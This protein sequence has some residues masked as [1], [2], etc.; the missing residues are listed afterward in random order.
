[1]SSPPLDP[2][3]AALRANTPPDVFVVTPR[4]LR[5][6]VRNRI[7]STA[8]D[9]L[10]V[11]ADFCVALQRLQ[12]W[13]YH[14]GK[15]LPIAFHTFCAYG[16]LLERQRYQ[17]RHLAFPVREGLERHRDLRQ[18]QS[19]LDSGSLSVEDLKRQWHELFREEIPDRDF[20]EALASH[21]DF[22]RASKRSRTPSAVARESGPASAK[23][24]AV[25]KIIG[26][27]GEEGKLLPRKTILRRLQEA[28]IS[29]GNEQLQEVLDVLRGEGVY[30]VLPNKRRKSRA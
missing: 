23:I 26:D 14:D 8:A 16:D 15:F 20:R 5:G 4:V 30:T 1:M 10:D 7:I 11:A 27:A 17:L 9:A 24:E 12:E 18:F 13:A 25:R 22:R 28:R 21:E 29:M 2:V 3:T 19:R 6:P